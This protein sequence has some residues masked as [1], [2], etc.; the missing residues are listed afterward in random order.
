[1]GTTPREAEVL[2]GTTAG[3]RTA[4][5]IA[6]AVGEEDARWVADVLFRL[7]RKGLVES[8]PSA[9]NVRWVNEWRFTD[10]RGTG[11]TPDLDMMYERASE[12]LLAAR[13]KAPRL[14]AQS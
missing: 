10:A 8:R 4:R 3:W 9:R 2:A 13:L 14:N 12:S 11:R 6:E 7:R 5:E 1:M